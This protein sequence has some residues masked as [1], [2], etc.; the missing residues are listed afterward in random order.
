MH[1]HM[2]AWLCASGTGLAGSCA[3]GEKNCVLTKRTRRPRRIF[4][5]FDNDDDDECIRVSISLSQQ[6][7]PTWQGSHSNKLLEFMCASASKSR[8]REISRLT[9]TLSPH[10]HSL[11]RGRKRASHPGSFIIFDTTASTLIVLASC[12][13][14]ASFSSSK[15]RAATRPLGGEGQQGKQPPPLCTS[16]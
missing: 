14:S 4:L 7:A 1:S 11:C 5:R 2:H 16:K 6:C 15:M 10:T 3:Q 12:A 13:A 8:M 9:L